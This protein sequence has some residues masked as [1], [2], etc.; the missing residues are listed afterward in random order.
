MA[1]M[2]NSEY[3]TK[4]CKKLKNYL[5]KYYKTRSDII[6]LYAIEITQKSYIYTH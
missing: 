6:P 3:K 5:K 2:L 4:R 1:F